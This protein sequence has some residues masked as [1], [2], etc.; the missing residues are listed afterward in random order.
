MPQDPLVDEAPVPGALFGAG[1]RLG[2]RCYLAGAVLVC[3]APGPARQP[4]AHGVDGISKK[5]DELRC[6][7]GLEDE[8]QDEGEAGVYQ[9]G[10]LRFEAP[11]DEAA[12]HFFV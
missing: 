2:G 5:H 11:R 9:T 8:R 3:L 10:T 6:R 1:C 7:V 12:E 4:R